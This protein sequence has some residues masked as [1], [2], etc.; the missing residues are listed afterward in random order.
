M[1]SW[2]LWW[3]SWAC[4]KI[5]IFLNI[6]MFHWE[7]FESF[8]FSNGLRCGNVFSSIHNLQFSFKRLDSIL[9]VLWCW[10]FTL[11]MSKI[12]WKWKMEKH[13]PSKAPPAKKPQSFCHLSAQA[14]S[15]ATYDLQFLSSATTVISVLLAPVTCTSFLSA[16]LTYYFLTI[17]YMSK[18]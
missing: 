3:A 12:E 18:L 6:K 5:R 15:L 17:N 4:H 16:I 10:F 11:Y 9:F 13:L 8:S 7:S 2:L 14:S 1:F